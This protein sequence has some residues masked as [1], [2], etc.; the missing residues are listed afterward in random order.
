MYDYCYL[1]CPRSVLW[2]TKATEQIASWWKILFK[3]CIFVCKYVSIFVCNCII[4]F[5]LLVHIWLNFTV[6]PWDQ[7]PVLEIHLESV[8]CYN[9]SNVIDEC[10]FK[11]GG[12]SQVKQKANPF[13]LLQGICSF[14]RNEQIHC[15]ESTFDIT[16]YFFVFTF[17]CVSVAMFL[18]SEKLMHD[19]H[20]VY[21]KCLTRG[22]LCVFW[23]YLFVA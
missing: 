9:S 15:L 17:R 12:W 10:N 20:C 6:K 3:V 2:N 1:N 13:Y 19:K 23:C 5:Y 22:I 14:I 8:E 16:S 11:M 7:V 4:G 18:Q 21:G